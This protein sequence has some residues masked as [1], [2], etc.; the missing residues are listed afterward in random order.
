MGGGG[1]VQ[2]CRS[3]SPGGGAP[4]SSGGEAE[5]PPSTLENRE[6]IKNTIKQNLT[7]FSQSRI[8]ITKMAS[9]INQYLILFNVSYNY[10]F[11]LL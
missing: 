3:G 8:K 10:A 1:G 5:R 2:C 4:S 11:M 9:L 7:T 6:F